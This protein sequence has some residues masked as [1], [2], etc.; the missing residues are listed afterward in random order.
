MRHIHLAMLFEHIYLKD[1]TSGE[2]LDPLVSDLKKLDRC[3]EFNTAVGVLN[4]RVAFACVSVDNLSAHQFGGLKKKCLRTGRICRF[5][6]A[7]SERMTDTDVSVLKLRTPEIHETHVKAVISDPESGR[8]YGVVS[9]CPFSELFFDV[10]NGYPA[11]IVHDL[12][13]GIVS[14]VLKLA[15]KKLIQE[16]PFTLEFLNNGIISF[17]YGFSDGTDKPDPIRKQC[18]GKSGSIPC[19]AVQKL[20][21]LTF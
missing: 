21:L 9:E 2:I 14:R 19:K 16:R 20:S 10:T 18:F 11:D 12:L 7:T 5:C 4:V 1:H 15:L 8:V 13:E 17:N 6:M 3:H